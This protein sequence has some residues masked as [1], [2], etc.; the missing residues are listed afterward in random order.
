MNV[1]RFCKMDGASL[2]HYAVRHYAHA[3]CGLK[4]QGADFLDNLTDWQCTRFP[5]RAAKRAGVLDILVRRCE[6]YE[7]S[8]RRDRE[9]TQ[10]GAL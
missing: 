4:A 1:C 10:A 5:L 7:E 2:I 9:L 3:D 6:R 8:E